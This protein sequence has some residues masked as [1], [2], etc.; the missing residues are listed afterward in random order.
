MAFRERARCNKVENYNFPRRKMKSGAEV[1]V[2]LLTR[3]VLKQ[4]TG[5]LKEKKPTARPAYAL[6]NSLLSFSLMLIFRRKLNAFFLL[7]GG[8]KVETNVFIFLY[9]FI[10]V[11]CVFVVMNIFYC[12]NVSS[13]P[14]FSSSS[15][16][17]NVLESRKS[18]LSSSAIFRIRIK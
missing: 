18:Q 15:L 9:Q 2:V 10:I 11:F 16:T 6:L 5:K 17:L 4:E 14:H 12:N 8:R 13:R 1:V 7:F 3:S